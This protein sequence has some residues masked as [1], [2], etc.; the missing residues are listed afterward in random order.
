M[1]K[2]SLLLL[3]SLLLMIGLVNAFPLLLD[4]QGVLFNA[5]NGSRMSGSFNFNM[6]LYKV[7]DNSFVYSENRT[8]SL[9]S[10]VWDYVIGNLIGLTPT[11]F[12]DDLYI[13]TVINSDVLSNVTL[14]AVPYSFYSLKSNDSI[15]LNGRPASDYVL[16]GEIVI[17]GTTDHTNLT[18][19]EVR[20][21]ASEFN[22][23]LLITPHT[24]ATVTDHTNRTDTEIRIIASEFNETLLAEAINNSIT[25]HTNASGSTDH[26]NLT[27]Q[28]ILDFEFLNATNTSQF[29]SQGEIVMNHTNTTLITH[30]QNLSDAQDFNQSG[31]ITPQNNLTEGDVEAF[32]NTTSLRLDG[33]NSPVTGNVQFNINITVNNSIVFDESGEH[34]I[35]KNVIGEVFDGI[36]KQSMWFHHNKL[37][38]SGE[39]SF[40]FTQ[41]NNTLAWMQVGRNNSYSGSGNSF[42]IIP[43]YIG[44]NN[45][46]NADGTINM[47]LLSDYLILCSTFNFPCFYA[48]DTL[49]RAKGSIPGGPLL[50]TMGD[51][52]VWRSARIHEGLIVDIDLDVILN[53]TDMDVIG[54][55]IHVRESR[56]EEVGVDEGENLLLLDTGFESG[57]INPFVQITGGGIVDWTAVDDATNCKTDSSFC[58]RAQGGSGSP[59]RLM[60][61][62]ISTIN[63]ENCSLRWLLTTTNLDSGD[64]FNFTVNNNSGSG[65]VGL[66][67]ISDGSDVSLTNISVDLPSNMNNQS[68]VSVSYFLNANVA[69]EQVF[70]DDVFFNC[71]A[72]VST[73]TNFTRLDGKIKLG[74]GECFIE[75]TDNVTD[76]MTLSCANINLIG[77]VIETNITIVNENA[78]GFVQAN[79]FILNGTEIF[80][81]NAF[82]ETPWV[83]FQNYQVAGIE[84]ATY[85]TNLTNTDLQVVN[86]TLMIEAVN[87]TITPHTNAS[88]ATD[89]T[90]RTDAEIRTI[91]SEFNETLFVEGRLHTNRTNVEIAALDTNISKG[92]GVAGNIIVIDDIRII[93]GNE[94]DVYIM[95]NTTGDY[96]ELG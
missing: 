92:G 38:P 56:V 11:I 74:Q 27:K 75:V 59:N 89:H 72:Q 21:I 91:A 39:I 33:V 81:W 10:G 22:E 95:F 6:S 36:A 51:L 62:N 84:N 90:N 45:F 86:E 3:I 31:N 26:T 53:N 64:V 69:N 70:V 4:Q 15:N 1:L 41:E 71:T 80:D 25:P 43:N 17:N 30:V 12:E 7:S 79:S 52:E 18:D 65:D 54:G 60:T 49:G 47:T 14:T 42:G 13:R 37:I 20:T 44:A 67:N 78:S 88:G 85:H 19:A 61:A 34:F 83:L 9:S 87:N 46:S 93:F 96:G 50:W 16:D 82:N 23:T 29:V 40:L 63:G 2:K 57:S 66:F 5:T 76:T 24:N 35:K 48:A 55:D 32:T 58:I 77:N 28:N 8:L 68:V 94:S 73:L